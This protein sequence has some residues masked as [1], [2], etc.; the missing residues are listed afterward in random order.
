M[1]LVNAT[2]APVRRLLSRGPL[3]TCFVCQAPILPS[4]AR[5]RLRGDTEVHRRCATY[6]V[7][8]GG[9]SGSRLGFPG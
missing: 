6:R 9:S 4:E 5:M 3:T 2:L 8:N 1:N 7:R